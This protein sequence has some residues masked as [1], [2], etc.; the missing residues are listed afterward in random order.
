LRL[1]HACASWCKAGH[2]QEGEG[3]LSCFGLDELYRCVVAVCL[4]F[5][6]TTCDVL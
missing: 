6:C 2:C 1:S 3:R 4:K 5:P